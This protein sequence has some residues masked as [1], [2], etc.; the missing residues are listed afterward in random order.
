MCNDQMEDRRRFPRSLSWKLP[1]EPRTTK[2]IAKYL[3][4]SLK[5]RTSIQSEYS[6]QQM[7]MSSGSKESTHSHR[8]EDVAQLHIRLY[9][10]GHGR[11]D[12]AALAARETRNGL[13]R[14]AALVPSLVFLS[15]SLVPVPLYTYRPFPRFHFR[16]CLR[17]LAQ[18]SSQLST[19]Y[20]MSS[21]PSARV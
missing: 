12:P 19:N 6:I 15:S 8:P 2:V 1:C 11:M 17:A 7:M 20:K 14:L 4:A 13:A 9:F 10:P 16:K 3:K 18:K 21:R 5:G